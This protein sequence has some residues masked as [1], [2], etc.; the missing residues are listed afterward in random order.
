VKKYYKINEISKLYGIGKDSIRYYEKL[1]IL[2]PR[3]DINGYRLYSLK[4]MYKLN[5]IRD[6]RGL[7]FSM[8]QIKEYLE[9]QCVKNTL[10][11]LNQEKEHLQ[12]QQEV[13]KLREKLI[14]ER[15]IDINQS[16]KVETGKVVIK[17]IENRYCVQL[18]EHITMDEEV[19]F[20]MKKLEQKHVEKIRD[21]GNQ[22]IGAFFNMEDVIS[23][24]ANVFESIFF[25]LEDVT[26]D[27]DFVL[28]EGQYLSYFY[29]GTYEQS[30]SCCLKVLKYVKENNLEH[31]GK[32][33]EFYHI[34]NRDT[35]EEREFLTEIQLKLVSHS[36]GR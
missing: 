8:E 35:I 13:L 24:A 25:V 11:M 1:G 32:L 23:G 27:H 14:Q 36:S 29:R 6:L 34:D 5:M 18:S 22:T 28:P 19:D 16:L 15:I 4:E 2:K 3:R 31:D 33:F 12:K 7:D 10:D 17:T 9:N 20:L 26:D 30:K 21:F